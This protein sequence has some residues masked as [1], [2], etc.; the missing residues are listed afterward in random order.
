ME[1]LVGFTALEGA[2]KSERARA[3]LGLPSLRP[4]IRNPINHIYVGCHLSEEDSRAKDSRALQWRSDGAPMA[5][6]DSMGAH[7]ANRLPSER[8]HESRN[9]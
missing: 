4:R 5:I 2:Y 7:L 6:A 3:Q 9:R 8:A 1:G